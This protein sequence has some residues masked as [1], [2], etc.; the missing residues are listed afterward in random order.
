MHLP[1]MARL[2]RLASA[3]VMWNDEM[4]ENPRPL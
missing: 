2:R 4:T 1:S 3:P